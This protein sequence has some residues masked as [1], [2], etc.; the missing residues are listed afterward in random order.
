MTHDE[1]DAT[2]RKMIPPGTVFQNPGGGVS[3]VLS[4]KDGKVSYRRGSSTISV[5]TKSLFDA[6]ASFRGKRMSSA[7]LKSRWP[8]IFDSSA[9][10]AGHSCNATFLFLA[11]AKMGIASGITGSGV[12]GNPFLVEVRE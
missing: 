12:R 8:S 7:D 2:F 6:F 3:E 11:L 4:N 9:R 10:P 1:F 5:S